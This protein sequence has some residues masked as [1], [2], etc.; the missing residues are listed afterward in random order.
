MEVGLGQTMSELATMEGIRNQGFV[1]PP[2][3]LFSLKNWYEC[4]LASFKI[5]IPGNAQ[6]L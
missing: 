3:C 4:S 6:L 5:F 2:Q 1:I